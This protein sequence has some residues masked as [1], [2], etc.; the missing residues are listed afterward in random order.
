MTLATWSKHFC[1]RQVQVKKE[2]YFVLVHY[3]VETVHKF[4]VFI[5]SPNFKLF[6]VCIF[7][8]ILCSFPFG[9]SIV[10]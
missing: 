7:A 8:F 10:Q 4:H 3:F 5:R 9:E 1:L 6:K 2:M